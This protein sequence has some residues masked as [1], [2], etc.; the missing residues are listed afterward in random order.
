[1]QIAS[2]SASAH[3]AFRTL[4][5]KIPFCS[6]VLF[7]SDS[8]RILLQL[9]VIIT[10]LTMEA[11]S[12]NNNVTDVETD[13]TADPCFDAADPCFDAS[14]DHE[15]II[16]VDST[17]DAHDTSIKSTIMDPASLMN[18]DKSSEAISTKF[19]LQSNVPLSKNTRMNPVW[20]SISTF[21]SI[22]T[23]DIIN[24]ASFVAKVV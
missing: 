16:D 14:I 23:R 5:S 7:C 12:N 6:S 4:R 21:I 15:F 24:A 1:V 8:N 13:T 3:F 22:Q 19:K 10:L 11:E 2:A 17:A 9:V 20:T 18:V